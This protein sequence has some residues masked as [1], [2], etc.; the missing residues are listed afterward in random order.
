MLSTPGLEPACTKQVRGCAPRAGA[1][2]LC[3]P[4]QLGAGGTGRGKINRLK[5]SSLCQ[6]TITKIK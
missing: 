4:G 6:L 2:E 1:T 3:V 5:I